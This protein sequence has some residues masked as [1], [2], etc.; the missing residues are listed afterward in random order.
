MSKVNENGW[1]GLYEK[2]SLIGEGGNAKV[3]LVEKDGKE[4]ALKELQNK[5]KEKKS[6]L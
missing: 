2:K 4:F 1:I 6:G 3:F 5:S